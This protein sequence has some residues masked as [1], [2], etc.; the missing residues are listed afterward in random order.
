MKCCVK[1]KDAMNCK[2]PECELRKKMFQKTHKALN[3][4]M[5]YKPSEVTKNV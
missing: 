3:D 5:P 4:S 2:N 1:I